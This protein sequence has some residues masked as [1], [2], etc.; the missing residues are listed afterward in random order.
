[1]KDITSHITY[2]G[3]GYDQT[4]AGLIRKRAALVMEIQAHRNRCERPTSS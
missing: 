4:K 3:D 2:P 1:M